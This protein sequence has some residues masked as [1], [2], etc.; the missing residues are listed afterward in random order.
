MP[1]RLG[2]GPMGGDAD[3]AVEILKELD[4]PYFNPF[5]L[6][7]VSGEEWERADAV[8]PGEFLISIPASGAGRRDPYVSG[9]GHG[10][11]KHRGR[12]TCLSTAGTDSG[13]SRYLCGAPFPDAGT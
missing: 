5:C 13:A 9:G 11:W 3:Q 8:N 10:K 12:R 2:A 1:F 6:T 7:R 4:V